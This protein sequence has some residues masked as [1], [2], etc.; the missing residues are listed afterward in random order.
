MD[1]VFEVPWPDLSLDHVRECL[2]VAGDEGVTWEA[3]AG[4]PRRPEDVIRTHHVQRSVCGFANALGGFLILGAARP[5]GS[6]EWQLPG[7]V[8]PGDEP[9]TW[10]D[11]VISSLR[12]RPR[13]EAHVWRV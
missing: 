13:S 6:Q 3:K 4:D 1:S 8:F 10:L 12:P 5:Q 7:V 11:D 2:E 9:A